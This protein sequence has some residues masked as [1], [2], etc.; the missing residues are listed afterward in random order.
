MMFWSKNI[1]AGSCIWDM[2][3]GN[4]KKVFWKIFS[5]KIEIYLLRNSKFELFPQKFQIIPNTCRGKNDWKPSFDL[6]IKT[7]TVW[8]RKGMPYSLISLEFKLTDFSDNR[9]DLLNRKATQS[10]PFERKHSSTNYWRGPLHQNADSN[11][12]PKKKTS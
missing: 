7:L 8:K 5:S 2:M 1:I 6:C 3:I 11:E 4:C 9:F 10:L 12:K